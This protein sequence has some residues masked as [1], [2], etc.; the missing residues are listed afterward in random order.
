[1]KRSSLYIHIPF[2]LDICS[3]CDFCKFYYDE[4]Y[5]NKYLESLDREVSSFYYDEPMKSIYIGGGTP[6]CLNTPNLEKLFSITEKIKLLSQYEFTFEC[7]IKDIS[8]ELLKTLK[9]NRVNRIS[10]G[11]ETANEKFYEFLNR[12]NDK[13]DIKTK[14]SLVKKYFTNINIDLM[15]GFPNE[16]IKDLKKDLDFFKELDVPHISIYSLI[17]EENTK[18]FIQ[19]TK[20]LAEEIESDMYYYIIRYLK[21]LGYVH[22]E[23]SNFSKEGYQSIHN[24]TYWNNEE[25]YGFGLSSGGYVDGI[26]YTNTRSLNNYLRGNYRLEEEMISLRT[27]MENEMILGLRKTK[28]VN[29][30]HFLKKFGSNIEDIFDIINMINENWLQDKEGYISISEDKLYLSNHIL[31]NFIGGVDE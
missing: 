20:P 11:I 21:D 19:K 13:K 28:G 30:M 16:S 14:L 18:L 23:I 17:I 22:Y 9:A 24:L 7:N 31:V 10:I 15:Y 6:S 4:N 26:R 27:D 25:Y 1:M 2:C 8:E 29:K 3:Y 5:A 12:H